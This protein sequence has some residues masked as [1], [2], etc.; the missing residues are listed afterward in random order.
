MAK[1]EYKIKLVK[2]SGPGELMGEVEK[3][4]VNGE[5]SFEGLQFDQ[6]GDYVITAVP[7]TNEFEPIDF[8]ITVKPGEEKPQDPKKEEEPKTR[9][10]KKE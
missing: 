10:L 2:K 9:K 6:P 4:A 3:G 8:N 5:V 1:E 7:D